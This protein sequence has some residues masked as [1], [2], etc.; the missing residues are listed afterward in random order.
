MPA[1]RALFGLPILPPLARAGV[2]VAVVVGVAVD[3]KTVLEGGAVA[4]PAV[5]VSLFQF[6][7][8][9]EVGL[10]RPALPLVVP[11]FNVPIGTGVGLNPSA[12]CGV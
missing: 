5:V 10:L 12:A 2:V 4:V 11:M 7:L 9:S 3:P 6:K 8:E 1:L